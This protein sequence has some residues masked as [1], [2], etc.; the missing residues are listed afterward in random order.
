MRPTQLVSVY[1]NENQTSATGTASLTART[2]FFSLANGNLLVDAGQT[3]YTGTVT[4]ASCFVEVDEI[5]IGGL[6]QQSIFATWNFEVTGGVTGDL[7]MSTVVG[8]ATPDVIDVAPT[9]NFGSGQVGTSAV[10]FPTIYSFAPDSLTLRAYGI[11]SGPG[12]NQRSQIS[13]ITVY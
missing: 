1:L 10:T 13:R 11:S 8:A 6:T 2:S 5:T 9:V 3:T 7:Q 12:V 4:N